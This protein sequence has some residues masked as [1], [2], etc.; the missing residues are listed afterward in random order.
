MWLWP[1]LPFWT[2][3]PWGYA[4]ATLWNVCELMR[5]RTPYAHIVFGLIL[6]RKGQRH[7][8]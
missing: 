1:L 3:T 4:A 7:A 2:Y 6:G 5:R 8:P